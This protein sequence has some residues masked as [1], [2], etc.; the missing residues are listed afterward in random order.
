MKR[1]VAKFDFFGQSI[2]G[3]NIQGEQ[4]HKTIFSSSIGLLISLLIFVFIV[5]RTQKLVLKTDPQNYEISL[6]MNL[7]DEDA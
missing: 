7:L 1:L 5:A 6:G 2:G 3:F 4:T